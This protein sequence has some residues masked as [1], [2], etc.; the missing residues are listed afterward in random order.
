[1]SI[2]GVIKDVAESTGIALGLIEVARDL[3]AGQETPAGAR[4]R[5]RDILPEKSHSEEAAEDI[6]RGR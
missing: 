1:V 2:G 5:V 6:E 3:L 4:K